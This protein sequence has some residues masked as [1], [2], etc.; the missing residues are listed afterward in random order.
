MS[1]KLTLHDAGKVGWT[2]FNNARNI[3]SKLLVWPQFPADNTH[4]KAT[5]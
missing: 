4:S 2:T 5:H 1:Q 3:R